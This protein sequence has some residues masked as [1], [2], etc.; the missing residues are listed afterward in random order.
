M[1]SAMAFIKS[2][3]TLFATRTPTRLPTSRMPVSG[4]LTRCEASKSGCTLFPGGSGVA[5]SPHAIFWD[6]PARRVRAA[7]RT[8]SLLQQ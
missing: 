4:Y 8:C 7:K 6:Y 1:C 3:G 5:L 2:G